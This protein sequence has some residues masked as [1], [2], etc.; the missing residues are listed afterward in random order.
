MLSKTRSSGNLHRV[1][2]QV[3]VLGLLVIDVCKKIP[4]SSCTFNTTIVLEPGK[5]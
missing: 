1:I 4:Y 3:L 2:V 5:M